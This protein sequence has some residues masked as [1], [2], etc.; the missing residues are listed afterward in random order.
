MSATL[1]VKLNLPGRL[2]GNMVVAHFSFWTQESYLLKTD[3]LEQYARLAGIEN[4][5]HT[6]TEKLLIKQNIKNKILKKF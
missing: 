4:Y 3:I 2:I 5:R 6:T 1:P